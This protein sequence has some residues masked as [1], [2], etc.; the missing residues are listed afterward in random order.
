L[1]GRDTANINPEKPLERS[2]NELH[3][4]VRNN[5]RVRIKS[6]LAIVFDYKSFQI[7]LFKGGRMLIKNVKDEKSALRVYREIREKLESG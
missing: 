5:F 1:C 6:H 2:F 3:V 4:A 7:S